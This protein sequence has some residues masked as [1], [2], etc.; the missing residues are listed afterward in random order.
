MLREADKVDIVHKGLIDL[1]EAEPDSQNFSVAEIAMSAFRHHPRYDA[2]KAEDGKL[3]R[4][5]R[6]QSIMGRLLGTLER[7]GQAAG[8]FLEDDG[9]VRDMKA[10]R[11]M[12][13]PKPSLDFRDKHYRLL[14][15]VV[16]VEEPLSTEVI[17]QN[18]NGYMPSTEIMQPETPPTPL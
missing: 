11:E 6:N 4:F 9:S 15:P 16:E 2:A 3:P 17:S 13:S 8:E 12:P 10:Y 14:D 5:L 7:N 18:G 1:R